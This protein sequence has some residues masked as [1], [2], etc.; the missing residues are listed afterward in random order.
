LNGL[1]RRPASP[2]PLRAPAIAIVIAVALLTAC[3]DDPPVYSLRS[4]VPPIVAI[5]Q[6]LP[7]VAEFYEGPRRVTFNVPFRSEDAGV[8]LIARLYLDLVPG[9]ARGIPQGEQL[10]APG[11]FE[12]GDRSAIIDWI[13]PTVGCHTLTMIMTYDGN[14]NSISLLPNDYSL[15]TTVVWWLLIDGDAN[16]TPISECPSSSMNPN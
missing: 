5:G 8:P 12:D 9:A 14:F 4:Q 16:S 10:I 1:M 2:C 15:A 3:L 11:Y 6:V 7:P 13:A